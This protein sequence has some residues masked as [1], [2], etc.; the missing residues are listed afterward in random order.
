[1]TRKD[2]PFLAAVL[3]GAKPDEVRYTTHEL[4]ALQAWTRVVH[5]VADALKAEN[6]AFDSARFL[7][8][9]GVRTP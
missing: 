1:M 2:Y 3:K 8:A 5:A 6:Q 4:A 9:A 7:K